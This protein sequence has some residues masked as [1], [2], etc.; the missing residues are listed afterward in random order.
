MTII[1]AVVC[2]SKD[3][4]VLVEVC[5]R[6]VKGTFGTIMIELL[7]HLRDHPNT[8]IQENDCKTFVQRNT[9]E[10][11]FF[12]HFLEACSAASSGF[13]NDDDEDDIAAETEDH[14]FHVYFKKGVYYCCLSDDADTG[15]QKVY[16]L[17]RKCTNCAHFRVFNIFIMY[18]F[19]S[20][21]TFRRLSFIEILR[22]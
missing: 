18:I 12:S 22:S 14:Y 1:Y 5:D 11:D 20:F 13:G 9:D 2:R 6:D 8:Y 15:D 21:L 17:F 10:I 3:A 16:V 19:L 4:A 7:Q